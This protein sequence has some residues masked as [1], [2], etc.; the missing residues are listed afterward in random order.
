MTIKHIKRTSLNSRKFQKLC[1]E[2]KS[3][4]KKLIYHNE[5]RWLSRGESI[6]RAYVLRKEINA[7]LTEM[8]HKSFYTH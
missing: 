8:K 1:E 5:I 4:N 2:Y 3:V 7:F 6:K